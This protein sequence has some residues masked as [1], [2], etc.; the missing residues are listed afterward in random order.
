MSENLVWYACYGSNLLKE[1]FMCYIKGGKCS[2]NGKLYTG[3]EDKSEPQ[4]DE[5][6]IIKHRIY[7]GKR[8]PSWFKKGVAFLDSMYNESECTLGRIYL[9]TKSQFIDVQSQEGSSLEWYGE[10]IHLGEKDGFEIKTLTS[11]EI[12]PEKVPSEYYLKAMINGIKETYPEKSKNEIIDYLIRA[13][14][15]ISRLL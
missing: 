6:F 14:K 7:F 5:S 11:K 2:Y 4:K 3:C 8:S 9:I 12:Q 13:N 1:R 15:H 10:I